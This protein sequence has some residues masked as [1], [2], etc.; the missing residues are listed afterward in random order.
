MTYTFYIVDESQMPSEDA[1]GTPAATPEAITALIRET[2]GMWAAVDADV[3]EY[4]ALWETL[5]RF[6]GNEGFLQEIAFGGSPHLLLTGY[7]GRWRLGYFEASLCQ[8]LLGA[9]RLQS[10]EIEEAMKGSSEATKNLYAAFFS[11]LEDAN[12]RNFAVAILHP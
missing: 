8:H 4:L 3:D 12:D 6:I 9:F 1:T 7:P 2:G 10:A 11:A 5:D